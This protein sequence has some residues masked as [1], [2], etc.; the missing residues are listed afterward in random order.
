MPN[1]GFIHQLQVFELCKHAPAE[2]HPVYIAWKK[3]L[4]EAIA[5]SQVEFVSIVPVV[6]NIIYL[7]RY[8]APKPPPTPSQ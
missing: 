4:D 1:E 8:I 3:S 2:T 7:S 6:D 5:K